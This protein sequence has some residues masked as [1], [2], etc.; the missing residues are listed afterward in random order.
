MDTATPAAHI[1]TRALTLGY[2]AQPVLRDVSFD[3]RH[4]EIFAIIGGS[5]CG[6]S[7]LLRHLIG[8][9]QPLKGQILFNGEALPPPGGSAREAL[10]RRLG[11]MYQGGA[12]WTSLTLAENVALPL[13]EHTAL[14]AREINELVRYK[15]ALVGLAGY[16]D[17][18]P[19]QISGGMVKRASLARAIA[20]DPEILFLDEPGAGLDPLTSRLLDELILQ[21]RATLRTTIVMVTH[22]LASIFATADTA[23]FL[24]ATTRTTGALGPPQTLRQHSP[25]P[26][27]RA[28][29][30]RDAPP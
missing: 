18:R 8:L 25:N 7:T 24:D 23:L 5:G 12:L 11:V 6:K 16:E 19:A 9:R 17:F 29:L 2:G 3:I 1:S 15:L 10:L 28:F 26:R 27:V 21:I 13:R 30:N 20:L 4:G 22:E 14:P